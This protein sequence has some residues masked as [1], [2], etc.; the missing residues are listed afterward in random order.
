MAARPLVLGSLIAAALLAAPASAVAGFA[1]A[2]ANCSPDGRY[3]NG[4]LSYSAFPGET[5]DV[6][7]GGVSVIDLGAPVSAG[8]GCVQES[9]NAARCPGV[10]LAIS[11]STRVDAGD[12]DDKVTAPGAAVVGG[13]GNDTLIG[14]TVAGDPGDDRIQAPVLA[15][16]SRTT[17]VAVDLAAGVGGS[18]GERDTLVGVKTVHGGSAAD[19]LA[20][21]DRGNELTGGRGNDRIRGLGG[22]DTLAGGAGADT[23]ECG[24]GKD[25]V[26][27]EA[28]TVDHR[29]LLER[30]C[31]RVDLLAGA[32]AVVAPRVRRRRFSLGLTHRLACPCRGR[33]RVT[34]ARGTVLA[35]GRTRDRRGQVSVPLTSAGKRILRGDGDLVVVVRW[36][37]EEEN[38][39][40]GYRTL[41]RR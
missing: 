27:G 25:Y 22:N 34:T 2:S 41:L 33:L 13:P 10:G 39:R 16:S 18:Q 36:R 5:N 20:G 9:A 15:Y 14:G 38:K 4:S 37:D 17:P 1:S 21:N 6:R 3:C 26:G 19:D 8:S 23:I 7:L 32:D 40:G 29:D 30:D 11:T 24:S 35:K 31:E 12:G 28:D